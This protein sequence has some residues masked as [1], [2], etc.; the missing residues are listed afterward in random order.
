M[1]L[2]ITRNWQTIITFIGTVVG[3]GTAVY[4]LWKYDS[5]KSCKDTIDLQATQIKVLKETIGD[6]DT[7]LHSESLR[8][9]HAEAENTQLKKHNEDL[10][11]IF[12]GRS[13][14]QEEFFTV[15]LQ[16]I[17]RIDRVEP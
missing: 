5:I 8:V 1:I 12:Q 11:A 13:K 17:R 6:R 7:Q 16:S 2:D 4:F 15:G 3:I 10:V 14:K 9:E